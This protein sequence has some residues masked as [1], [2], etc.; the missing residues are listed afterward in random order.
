MLYT[1]STSGAG[2]ARGR[3]GRFRAQLHH[4]QLIA[5]EASPNGIGKLAENNAGWEIA[6][7]KLR[8]G[9][10]AR[11][12]GGGGVVPLSDVIYL[13]KPKSFLAFFG[14]NLEIKAI[15]KSTKQGYAPCS[16]SG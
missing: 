9:S 13:P 16:G 11:R 3:G 10:R 5:R 14:W 6:G 4:Q 2:R 8:A 12:V 1:F 15:K 7:G